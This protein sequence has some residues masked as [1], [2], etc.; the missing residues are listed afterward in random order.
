MLRISC[1]I[2]MV[3][4]DLPPAERIRA[5]ADAGVDAVE[6]WGWEGKDLDALEAALKD[7]GLPLAAF[8]TPGGMMVDASRR[9][10]FVAG[11]KETIPVAERLG[12]RTL[13]ATT[14]QELEGVPRADQHA[15]VVAA[16]KAAAPL[17]EDHGIVLTLEPLNVLVDHAGYYLVASA[18]GFQIVDEVGSPNVKLLYDIYHQQIS[19]G[20][21]IPTLRAHWQQIGH[22]HAAD[23]PGRHEPGTGEIN[24]RNV[25]AAIHA[26]EYDG[27]VG[28]EY[29]PTK[30]DLETLRDVVALAAEVKQVERPA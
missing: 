3:L 19:E 26:L 17:L 27:Y 12:C 15:A 5:V 6:F 23:H 25:F 10:E 11:V 2:E 1:C 8:C 16:L 24:Y 4:R 21:L 9:E 30:D 29:R 28:M 13:I 7:A 14:G 20:N 22:F 18:E